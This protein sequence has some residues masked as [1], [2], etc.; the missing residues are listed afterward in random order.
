MVY[1]AVGIAISLVASDIF[2]LSTRKTT[3]RSLL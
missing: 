1:I 2:E 3:R